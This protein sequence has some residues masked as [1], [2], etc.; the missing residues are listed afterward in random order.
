MY[1][2]IVKYWNE[3]SHLLPGIGKSLL[4]AVLIILGGKFI[5]ETKRKMI[6]KAIAS[7]KVKIDE[8][9]GTILRVIVNYGVMLVCA[10]MVLGN[11]GI[12]TAGLIAVLGTAG[13]A[14][15]LALKDTLGNIASGVV[16]LVL[17]PFGKGDMIEF[18]SVT[19]IVREPG[20]FVTVME[21]GDGIYISVPNSN[22]WGP[23]LKNYSRNKKRRMDIQVMVSYNDS[24]ETAITLLEEIARKEERFLDA[25]PPQVVVQ[26]VG[27]YGVTLILR[28]WASTDLF[29]KTNQDL[30]RIIKEKMEGAGL[31]VPVPHRE[32]TLVK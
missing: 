26:T 21:T 22:L 16:L 2:F 32:I 17:R 19:G 14:I 9:L 20:L 18:G 24:L 10:I 23:P 28:A 15:G 27:E 6:T 1:E 31:R 11:F 30:I 13:V 8:H 4:A 3:Y 5:T 12:N 7:N 25:P 29:F